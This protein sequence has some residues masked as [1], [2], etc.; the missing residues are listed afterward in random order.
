VVETY[1][2]VPR[3]STVDVRDNVE[4]YPKSPRPFSVEMR[5]SLIIEETWRVLRVKLEEYP[6]SPVT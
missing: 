4:T 3:P 6:I 1:P 2:Y 5:E